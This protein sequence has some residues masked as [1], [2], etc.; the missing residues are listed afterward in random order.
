[1]PDDIPNSLP[2]TLSLSSTLVDDPHSVIGRD[3]HDTS[4]Q[5]EIPIQ[6]R[7]LDYENIAAIARVL[8]SQ[9]KGMKKHT[10]PGYSLESDK[11]VIDTFVENHSL[12]FSFDSED[13]GKRSRNT[14]LDDPNFLDIVNLKRGISKDGDN[15][16]RKI[17]DD[18][19]IGWLQSWYRIINNYRPEVWGDLLLTVAAAEQEIRTFTR[20]HHRVTD[21][22][23]VNHL[24]TVL[25][26]LQNDQT[27]RKSRLRYICEK[28]RKVSSSET[29]VQAHLSFLDFS[30]GYRH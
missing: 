5:L 25:D 20:Q 9:E 27:L 11:K 23:V 3:N 24:R 16:I 30:N 8:H 1:M 2:S 22:I 7:S 14:F 6:R 19:L 29:R 12:G 26:S 13:R 10:G 17:F 4:E 28:N 15:Y 18:N 21:S